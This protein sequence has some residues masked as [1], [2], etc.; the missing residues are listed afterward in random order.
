MLIHRDA[1]VVHEVTTAEQTRYFLDGALI[2]KEGRTVATDGHMLVRFTG[3]DPSD[4]ITIADLDTSKAEAC[5]VQREDLKAILQTMTKNGH[6]GG[7]FDYVAV[8]P[9][10][11]RVTLASVNPDRCVKIETRKVDG[12]FPAYERVLNSKVPVKATVIIAPDKLRL[13][14]SMAE[15]VKATAITFT[16]HGRSKQQH[17]VDQVMFT[18]E[19][20]NGTLDG[21]IMPMRA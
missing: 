13:L 18:A 19:G 12:T 7:A 4:D 21:A 20:D 15:K 8:V 3:R 16:L 5:I 1:F 2:D 11:Q 17:V 9:N 6:R 10:G 14:A